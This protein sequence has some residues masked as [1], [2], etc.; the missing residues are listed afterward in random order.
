MEKVNFNYS[1]KN[2]PIPDERTY[3]IILVEKIE[4]VLKR[5]RWKALFFNRKDDDNKTEIQ[6]YGLKSDN[7]PA[8][9]KELSAFEDDLIQLVK[10]IKFR[11]V[12]STLQKRMNKDAKAVKS[13]TKLYTSADKTSNMYKLDTEEYNKLVTNSITKDYK[14]TDGKLA[15]K[16][17]IQGTTFAKEAKIQDKLEVNGTTNCFIT[18][19]DHKENFMNNP[20]TR[21][22]NPAKNEVGRISKVILDK[23]NTSLAHKLKLNQWNNTKSVID[24]FKKIE[25]KQLY[26]FMM[27]DIKDYYPS[28]KDKLLLDAINFARKHTQV[29]KKDI[30]IILHARKSL[31]FN[32]GQEWVKKDDPE[33]DVTM[34]AFDGAEVCTLV[35]NFLLS[36]L[37]EKYNGEDIGLYRDDGLSVF[38]NVNGQRAEK[39]KKDFQKLFKNH[40]L[41]IVISCNRKV[42]DY[43]DVTL[44]LNDGSYRPYHKPND[45]ITYI[46]A[47]S[48][49]PPSIIKQLPLSIEKRL[50]ELSSS[51]EIFDITTPIYQESLRKSGYKHQLSYRPPSPTNTKRNRPRKIIWFNPPFCKSVETNVG[52]YFLTLVQKHFPPHHKFRKIFNKNNLKVSYS[53]LPNMKSKINSHNKKLL[54]PTNVSDESKQICNCVRTENCPMNGNCLK[55]E[56]VYIAKINSNLPNYTEKEYKGVCATTFKKRFSNYKKEFNNAKYRKKHKTH[57]RSV[58]T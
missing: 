53:C 55:K 23:I 49:H 58:V 40:G 36:L 41:D 15:D 35:G 52:R 19:K 57:R 21:L 12:N 43:L 22:I 44:N 17:N 42:V 51:K 32:N 26:K 14:K 2:I 25:N 8:Q 9:V 7:C 50:S 28:I 27:F 38:K 56:I 54:N 3:K 4:A 39:I 1:I 16:I 48:N 10:K 31:L 33:F 46:H 45:E 34:G 29:K 37:S 24:W 5:M 18:L 20:S 13:S 47:E 11:K 6:T 30:D